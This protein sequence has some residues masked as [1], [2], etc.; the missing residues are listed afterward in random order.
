M[1]VDVQEWELNAY[2]LEIQ[3]ECSLNKY[4][5]DWRPS[6]SDYKQDKIQLL[7]SW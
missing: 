7:F 5:L 4:K 2:I 3:Q 1:Q 6:Q